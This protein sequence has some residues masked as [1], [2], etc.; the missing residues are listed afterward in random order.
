MK[1]SIWSLHDKSCLTNSSTEDA[2]VIVEGTALK[3]IS[4]GKVITYPVDRPFRMLIGRNNEPLMTTFECIVDLL[5]L[6]RTL[7]GKVFILK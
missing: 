4:L 1:C 3:E 2:G 7:P 5:G 6:K